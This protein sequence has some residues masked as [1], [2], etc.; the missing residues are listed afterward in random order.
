MKTVGIIVYPD[1]QVLG[2]A[3]STVFEFANATDRKS[4]V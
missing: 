1:F 4:V 3:V 2:L